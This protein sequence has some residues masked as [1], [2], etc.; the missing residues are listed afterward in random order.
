MRILITSL[1]FS[2]VF[3]GATAA[4]ADCRY[5]GKLYPEGTAIGPYVCE[6]GQWVQ[7]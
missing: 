5:N 2:A 1:V 4:L 3:M 7:K 6:G